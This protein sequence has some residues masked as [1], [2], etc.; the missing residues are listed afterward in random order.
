MYSTDKNH[1]YTQFIRSTICIIICIKR[2]HTVN[3][4]NKYVHKAESS[5][6]EHFQVIHYSIIC[7]CPWSSILF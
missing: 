1:I 5:P 6:L 7:L 2:I 4:K 3:D